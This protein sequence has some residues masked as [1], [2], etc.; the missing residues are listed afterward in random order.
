MKVRLLLLDI[1][2]Q[3][4]DLLRHIV[5]TLGQNGYLVCILYFSLNGKVA[6]RNL[7]GD[8]AQFLDGPG[9]ASG[10]IHGKQYGNNDSRH[11]YQAADGKCPGVLGIQPGPYIIEVGCFHID[12]FLYS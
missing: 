11:G 8:A 12:I 2:Y 1:F 7:L 3:D 10:G 5:E 9:H 4:A 6:F